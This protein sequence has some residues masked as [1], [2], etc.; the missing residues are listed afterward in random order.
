MVNFALFACLPS[1]FFSRIPA[2][3]A[4]GSV[5]E[6]NQGNM[7]NSVLQASRGRAVELQRSLPSSLI[8]T[9]V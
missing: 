7:V 3:G 9:W 5:Y 6:I 4:A 1:R 2:F 8:C